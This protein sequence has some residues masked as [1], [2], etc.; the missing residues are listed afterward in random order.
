MP[1]VR[2]GELFVDRYEVVGRAG[3]GGMGLVFRARDRSSG[4]DVALKLLKDPDGDHL[5]RFRQ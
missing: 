4:Q 1:E 3:E 2:V 5:E